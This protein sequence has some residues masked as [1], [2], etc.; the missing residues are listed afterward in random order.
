MR[1]H[2]ITEQTSSTHAARGLESGPAGQVYD[3]RVRFEVLGSMRALVA[4]PSTGSPAG[5]LSP[6]APGRSPSAGPSLGGPKQ[7]LV[8]ALLLTQPNTAVSID[9]LVDGVWNGN[10]PGTARHTLQAYVSEL[11]KEIGPQL[12]RHGTGYAVEVDRDTLDALD[13]EARVKVGR[14]LV[15]ADPIGAVRELGSAIELWRGTAFEDFP[16][17]QVLGVERARLEELR[18]AASEDLIRAR[19]ALGQHA[20]VIVELSRLTN[21]HPY[22][23]ELRA[24]YMLALYR[25]G[26]QA[27]ALRE[28]Q[29]TRRKLDE[30]LGIVPSP[31]LRRLEEQILLQDPE[32]EPVSTSAVRARP[33]NLAENPYLG[34]RAFQ[35]EDE[36]RFFGRDELVERLVERVRDDERF[37]AVVGA[38]GS[39]K[40]S[41]V[42]AGLVPRL[43]RESPSI[44]VV[45]MQPGAQPFAELEAATDRVLGGGSRIAGGR[46]GLSES[47]ASAL[48]DGSTRLLLVV[49]QFEELFTMV[50]HDVAERFLETLVGAARDP[51]GH[52][53][54]VVTLRAD[55]YDRPLASS[56]F[57]T[58]F[59]DN[60]VNVVALTP[61]QLE[62][63]A[64]MPARRVDV[65]LEP[66]L[67]GR[68][69]AD[70]A[71]Q[72]NALPLFQ[73][74]LTELF[75]ERTSGVLELGT[76]ER[77]GGVRK[78]VARRA[79]SL[80]ERF[81]TDERE[82]AR[83]LFL[84]IATISDGIIGRRRVPASELV[85]LDV[86]LVALQTA[87]DQFAR[88]RLL[89]LDRDPV[90]GN[91][92]IEVAHEALLVEWSRLRE[93]ID[94]SRQDLI[95]H[96]AFAAA[97]RE[98]EVA[99]RSSGY[100]LGGARLED[101]ERWATT[102]A[103]RLTAIEQDFL[104]LSVAARDREQSEADARRTTELRRRR[105]SRGQ[106]AIL[107]VTAAVLVGMIA[108]PLVAS[109]ER[110]TIV[111][112]LTSPREQSIFDELLARGVEEAAAENGLE[113]HVLEPP[114]ADA[115]DELRR[116]AAAEPALLFGMYELWEPFKD[117]APDFPDTTFVA[118]DVLD[119]PTTSNMVTVHFA[120]EQGSFLVGAAAALESDSGRIGYIGAN[121]M[122]MLEEFRSGFE[123]GA[124]A[125]DSSIVV[126]TALIRPPLDGEPRQ[127]GF[128][129]AAVAK[130]IASTMYRDHG[131]DVIFVAAGMSGRGVA[132]AAA[133]LST[134][135][136][137][138]WMIG[139]DNDQLFDLP[140]EQRDHVLT[141]MVKRFDVAI[142]AVTHESNQGVLEVPSS[143]TF[144]LADGGIGYTTSGGFLDPA[145]IERLDSFT[146]EIV[147]G[148]RTVEATPTRP[149]MPASDRPGANA[150]FVTFDGESC[151]LDGPSEYQVGEDREFV[152]VNET[153][154]P[155]A[156]LMWKLPDGTPEGGLV[157]QVAM[158]DQFDTGSDLQ[159][160]REAPGGGRVV[161]P[162]H[163]DGTGEWV[164]VCADDQR[165]V[166]E[167]F[168]VTA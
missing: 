155:A 43:R 18:V 140:A 151:V 66:R 102:T 126:E 23:E 64:T 65:D 39:G 60:V 72:P 42:Q 135:G 17:Q 165:F 2:R 132:E 162:V 35:E 16:D 96:A 41:V 44:R 164:P 133:E 24:L 62:A 28:Y 1:R 101:Y 30:D 12:E 129:H 143:R 58:I 150:S 11:R 93:W 14:T 71:G 81:T 97:R 29:R 156:L 106:L 27:D 113:A 120:V 158:V 51:D 139:V 109:D 95:T 147:D 9:R 128:D 8:L 91:P 159:A 22:R 55:F 19:L 48:P 125:V 90:S 136:R 80:Y 144:T 92:T 46:R 26:R 85:S 25:N 112:A 40:S 154:G 127:D 122:P 98:W 118:V 168:T 57:G 50:D 157:D 15:V 76:Y 36:S 121:S 6:V 108:Y 79:E 153:D 87:I 59:A 21:E 61:D 160:V 137:K 166:A 167:I 130:Q 124:A 104:E 56:S 49:D 31:R 148:R 10:P 110:D 152:L 100:L 73:F 161:V 138:L 123:Q 149:A 94:E 68:L 3:D 111:M 84:R 34:L 119:E 89:A 99:R 53:R 86:D 77:I 47:I 88:S 13:F 54:V 117:H 33:A 107:F 116:A 115:D 134:P 38:S 146:A 103:L 114:F 142:R 163:F 70:V 63:A 7:R 37:T 145:T 141:S 5:A 45:R 131:V 105:R 75:D 83:Q 4:V 82:A 52:L 69:I 20:D 78:A 74:A 67:I 32:L